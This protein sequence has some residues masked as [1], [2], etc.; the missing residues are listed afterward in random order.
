MLAIHQTFEDELI[1]F[2]YV[3]K[4]QLSFMQTKEKEAARIRF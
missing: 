4:F 1:F 3:M 2:R